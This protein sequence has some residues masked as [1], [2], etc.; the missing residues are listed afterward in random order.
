MSHKRASKHALKSSREIPSSSRGNK[1]ETSHNTPPAQRA[2]IVVGVDY[3]TT[4][5]GVSWV[6]STKKHLE[7][8]QIIRA[9]PGPSKEASETWKTPSRIAYAS[10]NNNGNTTFD[11]WGY[12]VTPRMK[13]YSW[14]KLLLDMNAEASEFDDPALGDLARSQGDGLLKVPY[15]KSAKDVAADYLSN[16]YQYFMAELEKRISPEVVR[17]TPLEFW[18]TVPAMWDDK[19]K[20]TTYDAAK[21]AGFALRPGDSMFL[22]PEP[23]AAA[24][25]VLKTLTTDEISNQIG[26]GD[27]ILV[28]DAGGGTVDLT[29]YCITQAHPNLLFDEMLVGAGGKCGSTCE[30]SNCDAL[31]SATDTDIRDR[32]RVPSV[33]VEKIWLEV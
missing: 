27:G 5:T 21:Q 15:H 4:Y 3:G 19:A 18:F 10:E 30:Y 9:W 8:V 33:D 12:L 17:V 16:I 26:V 1:S 20:K 28:C 22:L 32:S 7:D 29:T 13:S 6:E 23:Q 25:A 2:K 11:Q 31:C 14:T 24:V